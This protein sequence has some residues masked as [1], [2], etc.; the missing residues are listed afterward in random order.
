[1]S[2]RRNAVADDTHLKVSLKQTCHLID[3]KGLGEYRK[4]SDNITNAHMKP[5]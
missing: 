2:F 1:M 5:F 3:N 4:P